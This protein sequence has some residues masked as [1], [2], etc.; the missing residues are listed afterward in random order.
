[1]IAVKLMLCAMDI[2]RVDIGYRPLGIPWAINSGDI[3]AFRR[4]VRMSHALSCY[5]FRGANMIM[6][7]P[8]IAT[9]DPTKSHVVGVTP[10]T[11]QSQRMATKI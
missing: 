1:M 9:N 3:D 8:V 10:S 6:A 5:A 4:A 7:M 11:T 2:L